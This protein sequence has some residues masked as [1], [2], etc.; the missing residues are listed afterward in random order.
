MKHQVN[1]IY[2]DYINIK[3]LFT[4]RGLLKSKFS[5]IDLFIKVKAADAK[6]YIKQEKIL[7]QR[8]F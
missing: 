4:S 8:G 3:L 7:I 2:N 5:Y 6:P 1:N